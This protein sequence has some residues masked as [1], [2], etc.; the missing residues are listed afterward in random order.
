MKRSEVKLHY[1]AD[2]KAKTLKRAKWESFEF[3]MHSEDEILVRNKSYGTES[4]K[5]T[6]VVHFED[7]EPKHCT[8]K[9]NKHI[10]G[11]CK[12]RVAA[13][14]NDVVMGVMVG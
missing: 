10:E 7:N 9:A 4:E 8:C 5:H 14:V 11:P 13:A 2:A 6:H 12:H 3:L 1:V